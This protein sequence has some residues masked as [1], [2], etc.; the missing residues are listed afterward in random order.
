ML[1]SCIEAS[2]LSSPRCL[3]SLSFLD[4]RKSILPDG[5]PQF[6]LWLALG[7]FKKKEK[8]ESERVDR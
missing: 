4:K 1:S 2:L 6:L 5:I 7:Y 8:K 3:L